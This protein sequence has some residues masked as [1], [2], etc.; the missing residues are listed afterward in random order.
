MTDKAD[1]MQ[2][3]VKN[4]SSNYILDAAQRLRDKEFPI[5]RWLDDNNIY[6]KNPITQIAND[7]KSNNAPSKPDQLAE[8]IA[9]SVVLHCAD[10]W[11]Y[12]SHAID[13]LIT[14]DAANSVFMAYYAQ[15]RAVMSFLASEGIGIFS[16]KHFYFDEQGKCYLFKRPTHPVVKQTIEAW[17]DCSQKNIRLL[18]LLSLEG[19]TFE[20]WINA[21][22]KSVNSRAPIATA[23]ELLDKWSIDLRKLEKDRDIR[24]EASYHPQGRYSN[25]QFKGLK[26]EYLDFLVEIWKA[27]E[28]AGSNRFNLLD[29]HLLKIILKST[30]SN[31]IGEEPGENYPDFV[32]D[33]MVNLGLNPKNNLFKF[34]SDI[35]SMPFHIILEEAN[36]DG[37]DK[38]GSIQAMPVISRAYLLLR[39]ASAA[40][41]EFLSKSSIGKDDLLFWWK[42]FGCSIG[43]WLPGNE[44][45]Q[46]EELW[47]DVKDSV[48]VIENWYIQNPAEVSVF[49]MKQ[50]FPFDSWQ[51]KQFNRVGL[52]GIGL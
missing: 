44:P 42:E 10:G 5:R 46:M 32:K 26:K 33:A 2:A 41:Q 4:A 35:D 29:C 40:A 39:L 48:D 6:A 43:L 18:S 45:G 50:E 3:V 1:E 25:S 8:Y 30:F 34:L 27:S 17:A 21:A 19:K 23:K 9:A 11:T 14:G 20:E 36:K 38:D 37:I 22:Q 47:D 31:Q 13:N 7:T 51:V 52:W 15:L 49:K 12:F 24:N 16:N 28:P